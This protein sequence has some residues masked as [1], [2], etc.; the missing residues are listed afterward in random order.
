MACF[1]GDWNR[2]VS[3]LFSGYADR[4]TSLYNHNAAVSVLGLIKPRTGSAIYMQH[5]KTN[6]LIVVRYDMEIWDK[7]WAVVGHYRRSGKGWSLQKISTVAGVCSG[8][9]RPL[10]LKRLLQRPAIATLRGRYAF[11]TSKISQVS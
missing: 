9:E 6:G 5:M 2:L 8:M 4:T 3:R 10:D 11:K 7:L 1:V